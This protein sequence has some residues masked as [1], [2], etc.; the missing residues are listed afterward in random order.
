M[1]DIIK[2]I[3]G[4]QN[5]CPKK[6]LFCF[7][8]TI[9]AA[10]KNFMV[11]KSHQISLEK[12]IEAQAGSPVEY[13]SEF[14]KPE[15]LEPWLSKHFL[16]PCLKNILLHQS[17]WLLTPITAR[18]IHRGIIKVPTVSTLCYTHLQVAWQTEGSG[19]APPKCHAL[20]EM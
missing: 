3:I 14:R 6:P 2:E 18:H 1:S 20:Q 19:T 13:S 9:E 7:K 12:V 5:P 10:K 11:L 17:G 15:I 8:M 16:W 4:Q